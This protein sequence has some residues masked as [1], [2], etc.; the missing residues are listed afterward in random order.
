M[1]KGAIQNEEYL[2]RA[3][4]EGKDFIIVCRDERD[5]NSK[6]VSLYNARRLYPETDQKKIQIQK[7]LYDDKWIIKISREIPEVYEL[8]NGVLIAVREPLR[9]DSK[10]M[11][12]EMLGQGMKEEEVINILVERGEQ[13]E[14]VEEEI[15]RLSV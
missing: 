2:Q 3:L 10:E 13:K 5:A 9:G 12:I 6:R 4:I 1:K 7:M 15:R 8:L 11:L 14:S